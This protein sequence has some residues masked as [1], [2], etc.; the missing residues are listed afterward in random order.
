[1]NRRRFLV[2]SLA[3]AAL[4]ATAPACLSAAAS[5]V[6]DPFRGLKTGIAS[7]SLRKF[8]LDQAL[9]MTKQAGVKH[10]TL[11]DMH[12]PLKTTREERQ[13]ARKKI[14]EAGL[15]LMGCGVVY[16]K[17][18]EAEIRQVFEYARDAGMP[19]IVCSPDPAA[20]D[21]VEKLAKEFDILIAIHN[22]GPGDKRYPSP[23]DVLK[24]VKDRDSHMGICI[25]VGHSVRIGDNAVDVIRQCARR[26]YDYHLKDVDKAD[27][28]GKAVV[29]GQ[30]VIDIAGVLKALL[31]IKFSHHLALEHEIEP[32]APLPGI[33]ASFEHVKK[34]L[35]GLS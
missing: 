32:D 3:G 24:L 29:V 17:N 20:L 26:L 23:L 22:H 19:A 21:S 18:D 1:M 2:R 10:I 16:M 34:I 25:D 28:K 5:A 12:L 27:P 30:G 13:A 9:A 4:A 33:I 15:V 6:T 11:K 8:S 7:Y 31:E 14:A 35:A